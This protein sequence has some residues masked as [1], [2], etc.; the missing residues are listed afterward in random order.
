MFRRTPIVS[1]VEQ[2]ADLHLDAVYVTTPPGSH[3]SIVKA[4]YA[5]AI[6]RH[7]FVEKPLALTYADAMELS[8]LSRQHAGVTMVGY[9]KRFNVVFRHA[10]Q[11]LAEGSLGDIQSFGAHA[12]SSDFSDNEHL[13]HSVNRGGALKDIG[14]HAID[15]LLWFLGPIEVLRRA[16]GAVG[17]VTPYSA[18]A[19]LQTC[20]GALGELQ[21]SSAAK[22]YRLPEFELRIT[23][24]RATMHVN[25]DRLSLVLDNGGR[26]TW[27]RQDLDDRVPFLLGD[28]E[29][30]RE[31]QAF[32]AAVRGGAAPEADFSSAARVEQVSDEIVRSYAHA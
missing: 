27:Y 25:D 3:F 24:R 2:L 7:M 20:G 16:E 4:A 28:P 29:Y 9:Q 1:S 21:I 30:T 13:L 23:G 22:G 12:Y 8:Q 17:E 11:L 18:S 26:Q 5:R 31:D 6:A 10:K 14:C 19:A 15:L 32:I